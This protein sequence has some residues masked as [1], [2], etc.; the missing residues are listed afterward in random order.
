MAES[1][2]CTKCGETKP[3]TTEY[4]RLEKRTK[5]GLQSKCLECE[6]EANRDR[7]RRDPGVDRRYYEA[8]KHWLLPQMNARARQ[9]RMENPEAVLA[10]SR[11]WIEKNRESE[12]ARVRM[13]YAAH[14]A[15]RLAQGEEWRRANRDKARSYVR[16]RRARLKQAS[17][18]HTGEDIARQLRGQRGACWWCGKRFGS[19]YHV[20][21]RIP[22][23]RGGSNGPENI[24]L[25]CPACNL[26]KNDK[27]PWE[28]ANPR[29]L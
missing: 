1:R 5:V 26:K 16:N 27:M 10:V 13:H 9:R 20:D 29:L 8:N 19:T 24:V 23:S 21:H 2:A 25:T 17:G 22:I 14:A 7:R 12:R 11:A 28:M 4:F 18:T 15:K 6:R 3:A